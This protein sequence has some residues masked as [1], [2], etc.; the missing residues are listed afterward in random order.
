[1]SPA[2]RY[3]VYSRSPST[4]IAECPSPSARVHSFR[5]P[6]DG[7]DDASPFESD[8]KSRVGPPHCVQLALAALSIRV[9]AAHN[10]ATIALAKTIR[11]ILV[12]LPRGRGIVAR[13]MWQKA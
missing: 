11:L 5:G 10:A 6:P 8:M 4:R 1:M 2:G 12:S 7:Q 9:L 3:I 13:E